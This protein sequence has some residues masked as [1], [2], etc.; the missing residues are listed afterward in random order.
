MTDEALAA[1]SRGAGKDARYSGSG[2]GT[3]IDIQTCI[4]GKKP[5]HP[6]V[7]LVGRVGHLSQETTYPT[8][9][10]HLLIDH[11]AIGVVSRV[12]HPTERQLSGMVDAL[13]VLGPGF[14]F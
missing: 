3:S 11:K 12:H 1:E 8:V 13:N 2:G 6:N 5:R 4:V 14:G 10:G 7:G 9:G